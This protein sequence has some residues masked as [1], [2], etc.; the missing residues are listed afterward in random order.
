MI[1]QI[2]DW[3]FQVFTVSNRRYY[4]REAAEHCTC[5]YCENYYRAA[6]LAYPG[7]H[8]FLARFGIK[9]DGPSEMYPIEPTLYLAGYRVFGQVETYG[10][11]PMMVDGVPVSAEPVDDVHFMLEIGE[12]PLPWMLEEDPDEVVS[13]AN[14]PEFLEKM[15]LKMLK[16]NAYSGFISS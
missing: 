5:G 11:S 13:P 9:L 2:D 12:M 4:A 15:Y 7:L 14:E 1:I 6:S 16:R 3:K 10:K 8:E